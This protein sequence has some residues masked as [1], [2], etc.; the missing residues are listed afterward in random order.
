MTTVFRTSSIFADSFVRAVKREPRV[1]QRLLDFRKSKTQD[2]L[3]PF[4]KSDTSLSAPFGSLVPKLR[5]A[6]LTQ[7]TSVFY[8]LDGTDPREIKLYGVF[9]HAESGTGDTPNIRR[10]N[11]LAK[12]LKGQTFPQ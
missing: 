10:Q 11:A 3:A 1:A 12:T 4:G 5:H 8:T 6:H 7:D 9:N 2:P